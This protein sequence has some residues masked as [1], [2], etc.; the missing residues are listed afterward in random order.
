M[1]CFC[2]FLF[3]CGFCFVLLLLWV[4]LVVLFC[5]LFSSHWHY[6]ILSYHRKF[7]SVSHLQKNY[8]FIC[9]YVC[10]YTCVVST[11]YA[12]WLRGHFLKVRSLLPCGF[13]A[14]VAIQAWAV[15]VFIAEPAQR[16]GSKFI[17][18]KRLTMPCIYTHSSKNRAISQTCPLQVSKLESFGHP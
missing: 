11:A 18:N 6:R 8:L 16:L 4:F 17:Y 1:F 13:R 10:V 2:F 15:T 3:V 7:S 9:V 5:F 12:L 14:Q